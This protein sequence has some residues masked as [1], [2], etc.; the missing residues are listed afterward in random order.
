MGFDDVTVLEMKVWN[1]DTDFNNIFLTDIKSE[2]NP[3]NYYIKK[4]ISI[5]QLYI[6]SLKMMI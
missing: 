5:V 2:I 3:Y 1:S 4:N 6:N